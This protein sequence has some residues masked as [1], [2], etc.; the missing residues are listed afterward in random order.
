M[1]T[2]E[3]LNSNQLVESQEGA[4]AAS[5]SDRLFLDPGLSP[6]QMGKADS[7]KHNVLSAVMNEEYEK[8][9]FCLD[10][11]QKT[12]SEFKTFHQKTERFVSHAMDLVRAIRT[13][14]NFPGLN[15]LTRAKQQELRDKFKEHFNELQQALG[16]IEKVYL[17]LKV[18]DARSTV[19]LIRTF[20]YSVVICFLVWTVTLF[21]GGLSQSISILVDSAIGRILNFIF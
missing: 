4:E 10:Q 1:S 12:K 17:D 18:T 9:L 20:F 8:A 7:L 14:R 6:N 11:F 16:K 15:Q 5:E 19:W 21:A 13:K 2:A 3:K